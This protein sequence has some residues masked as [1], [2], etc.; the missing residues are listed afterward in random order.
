MDDDI[1]KLGSEVEHYGQQLDVLEELHD[2]GVDT[3]QINKRR[4]L[5]LCNSIN[6]RETDGLKYLEMFFK[7]L[8]NQL[9][10]NISENVFLKYIN[11]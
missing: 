9:K 1:K 2:A 10:I 5:K 4:L 7:K 8:C 11:L 6:I 3:A